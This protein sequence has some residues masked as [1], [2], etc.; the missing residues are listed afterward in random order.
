MWFIPEKGTMHMM[1]A[2]IGAEHIAEYTKE[3]EALG[4]LSADTGCVYNK[5]LLALEG[6]LDSMATETEK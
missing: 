3:S 1:G 4:A 2:A 6:Y 5:S